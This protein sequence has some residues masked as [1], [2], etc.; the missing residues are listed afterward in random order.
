MHSLNVAWMD[1]AARLEATIYPGTSDNAQ[2]EISAEKKRE[3]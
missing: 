1:Y 2:L 3:I